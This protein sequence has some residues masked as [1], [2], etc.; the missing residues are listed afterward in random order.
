MYQ[1]NEDL[2]YVATINASGLFNQADYEFSADGKTIYPAV[3]NQ[4]QVI[5][6]VV[7]SAGIVSISY[8][9]TYRYPWMLARNDNTLVVLSSPEP[10]TLN[11]VTN[12]ILIETVKL[13]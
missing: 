11:S 6:S 5:R 3:T 1:A 13:N 10:S 4:R 2:T 8:L 9:S 12:S 7:S